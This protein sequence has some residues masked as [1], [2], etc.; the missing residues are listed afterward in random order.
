M[1]KSTPGSGA[2]IRKASTVDLEISN[3]KEQ[4]E[5]GNY[6]GQDY[7]SVRSQLTAANFIVERR[8]FA[9]TPENNRKNQS[10]LSTRFCAMVILHG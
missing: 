3:G 9:S 4:V 1:I 6:V 5:I 10:R 7:E 2:R 8:D